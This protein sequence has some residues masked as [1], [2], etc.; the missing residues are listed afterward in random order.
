MSRVILTSVGDFD[1]RFGAGAPFRAAED[2]DFIYRAY[3]N[4]HR[5][6]YAPTL[7]VRHFHGRK[8][9]SEI[10]KIHHNYSVGNGALYL[11]FLFK[12]PRLAKHLYWNLKDWIRELLGGPKFDPTLNLSCFP[13][14][15]EFSTAWGFILCTY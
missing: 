2:A 4:G 14:C 10:A 5:V 8:N 1:V 6:D 11:K 15:W 3:L 12:S 7:V 9:L 13:S